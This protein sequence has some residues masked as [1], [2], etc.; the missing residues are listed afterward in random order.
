MLA[1][2][3][4]LLEIKELVFVVVYTIRELREVRVQI[5][6]EPGCDTMPWGVFKLFSFF[7][8]FYYL[9]LLFTCCL[10]ESKQK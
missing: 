5:T 2:A 4:N 1:T 9:L 6:T 10:N 8:F 7:L 3:F